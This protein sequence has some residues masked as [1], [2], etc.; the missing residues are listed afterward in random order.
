[1]DNEEGM[2]SNDQGMVANRCCNKINEEEE[3][4]E[5]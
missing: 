2:G 1:M 3:M 5:R 4:R